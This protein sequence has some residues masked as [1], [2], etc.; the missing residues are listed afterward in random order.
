MLNLRFVKEDAMP[1]LF[2]FMIELLVSLCALWFLSF[3]S[4]F[5]HELGHALGYMLATGDRR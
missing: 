5:M 1:K 3:L 4:T 2:A